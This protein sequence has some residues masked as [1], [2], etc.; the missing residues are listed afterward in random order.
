MYEHKTWEQLMDD[1]LT[2]VH[3]PQVAKREGTFVYDV[4]SPAALQLEQVYMQLNRVL[5]IGFAETSYGRYLD[6]RADE[7]GLK[8]KTS[9]AAQGFVTFKGKAGA[10]VPK[11][12]IVA[13]AD[14]TMYR[15]QAAAIVSD[16]GVVSAAVKA[17]EAGS[18]GNVPAAIINTIITELP[19]VQSV[20]N[21]APTLGGYD[22]EPDSEL[23][24][25][26]L[27]KVRNPATSGNA[28]H[29]LQWALEVPGIGDAK[30]FP[31]W[32]GPGTVKI[33]ALGSDKQA[34]GIE[35]IAEV[36]RHI[37]TMRPIGADVT[38]AGAIEVP[39]HVEV[40]ISLTPEA[41]SLDQVRAQIEQGIKEYLHKLAFKDR[42]V[43]IARIANVL[44][45]TP[46]VLDYDQLMMNG[47]NHNLVLQE[48][49]VAV[50]GT[51]KLL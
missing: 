36:R 32:Q 30:V 11:G 24:Q 47:G 22:G 37:E 50:L 20:F 31:I 25:R 44:L 27:A 19:G 28:D 39:V 29:Y 23:L 10:A 12:V 45:D 14:G 15:T 46:A 8:R 4:L 3:L 2:A 34:P 49:Q 42:V 41:G 1:L 9:E 21:A 48:D 33:V 18:S 16:T 7:H 35:V 26:L 17:L 5:Q 6:M 38:V 40:Q 51:V 43:R 13:T